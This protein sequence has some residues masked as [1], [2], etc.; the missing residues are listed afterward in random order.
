MA[1]KTLWHLGPPRVRIEE[2][3]VDLAA[4]ADNDF[5]AVA[6]VANAVQSRR[7]T[8][9]RIFR[10]LQARP[11]VSRRPFLEGVL[12]DVAAGTCSVLEHAYLT[13]IERPHG[14]PRARRQWAATSDGPIYRDVEYEPFGLVVELDGRLFHDTAT[15]RD[16]DLDRD[17]DA[18]IDRRH[19]VR[20][21]WGQVVG[22]PC[23]T[24]PRIARLLNARGWAG[25]ALACPECE[26]GGSQ[27]PD[28]RDQPRFA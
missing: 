8:A 26:R 18:A 17:L 28:D 4:G 3:I 2:A 13:R 25:Q 23:A 7:T 15:A 6:V 19:T 16:R 27:S 5:E 12:R 21:G 10:A 11:R 24:A 20:L 22:R 9:H 1:A 14:L